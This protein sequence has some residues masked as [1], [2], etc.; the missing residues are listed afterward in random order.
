MVSISYGR[1]ELALSQEG[2]PWVKRTT[3][4]DFQVPGVTFLVSSG[5]EGAY[6]DYPSRRQSTLTPEDP[7]ASPDVVAVGGTTLH[8]DAA[9]D[10]PGTGTAERSVGAGQR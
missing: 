5:D 2:S 10:Y 7:A 4:A 8:L 9:G 6:G 1:G 3:T